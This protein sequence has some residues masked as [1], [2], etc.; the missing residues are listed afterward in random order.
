MSD[1]ESKT[2]EASPKKLR[3]AKKKGQVA[4]SGDLTSAVSFLIFTMIAAVLGQYV[5]VNGLRFLKNS[6]DVDYGVALSGSNVGTMF[7]NNIIQLGYLVLPFAVIAIIIA[8]VVN[9]IQVGFIYTIEPIKPDFKRINPIEGFKNIF[10]Q[11]SVFTLVKNIIKLILVFY[12]TYKNLSKSLNQILNSG[13]VGSEKLFGFIVD[14]V[15]ALSFNIA[16]VMLALAVVDYIFQR[17]E[18]KKNLKMSKQDIKDEFKEME[19]NPQI[20]AARAQ[21]QKQ[22]AMSR[23]MSGIKTSTVVITEERR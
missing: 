16:I 2:E 5:Y 8:I 3:D 22:L 21:K 12:M 13:N 1:K 4:K 9:L 20:K 18:Y 17:R 23:M 19:G 15:R 11:K 14:F 10:S 6:L 7:I